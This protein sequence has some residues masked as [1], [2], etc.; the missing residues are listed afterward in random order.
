MAPLVEKG[1]A[2]RVGRP[3]FPPGA[4]PPSG[5]GAP[6]RPARPPG[7]P[8]HV[9]V[10][11]RRA[12]LSGAPLGTSG[13]GGRASLQTLLDEGDFSLAAFLLSVLGEGSFLD[14]LSF[15]ER[16]G[17]DPVTRPVAHLAFIH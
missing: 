2:A 3:R 8:R 13:A 14:L 9:E 6:P 16:H 17:P 10:F 12:E 1:G 11:T 4:P 15:L 5:G 7:G